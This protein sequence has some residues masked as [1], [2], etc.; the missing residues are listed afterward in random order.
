MAAALQALAS[1]GDAS[2]VR[3]VIFGD[4]L[5]LGEGAAALHD[6]VARFAL[7]LPIRLF[8]PVGERAMA[9]F[10]QAGDVRVRLLERNAVAADLTRRLE[11]E[12]GAVVLVKGSRGM[13]LEELADAIVR[14]AP[15]ASGRGSAPYDS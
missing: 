14:L 10:R 12:T 8:Y 3:A 4:M 7:G 5:G 13:H 11:A 9:A 6:E 15:P 2:T 1:F